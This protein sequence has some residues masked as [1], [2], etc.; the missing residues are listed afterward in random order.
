MPW[1]VACAANAQVDMWPA[2]LTMAGS[3]IPA[4]KCT[5][6]AEPAVRFETAQDGPPS[7]EQAQRRFTLAILYLSYVVLVNDVPAR[8]NAYCTGNKAA[9]ASHARLHAHAETSQA[10]MHALLTPAVTCVCA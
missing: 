4:R 2:A 8:C 3:A 5:G 7:D 9:C 10:D 1:S 6:L